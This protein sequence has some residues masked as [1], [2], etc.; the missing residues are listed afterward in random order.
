MEAQLVVANA[1]A[2]PAGSVATPAPAPA[3]AAAAAAAAAGGA[4]TEATR[5]S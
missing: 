2:T 3:A 4:K 1:A 5:G